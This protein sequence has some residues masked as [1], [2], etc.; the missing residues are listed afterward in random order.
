MSDAPASVESLLKS[1]LCEKK[2]FP[3]GDNENLEYYD[4]A[5][6]ENMYECRDLCGEK[7]KKKCKA[8]HVSTCMR[9]KLPDN[10]FFCPMRDPS[11]ETNTLQYLKYELKVN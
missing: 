8:N 7:C 3:Y 9:G 4:P 11:D 5:C 6:I 2:T 1:S 10:F